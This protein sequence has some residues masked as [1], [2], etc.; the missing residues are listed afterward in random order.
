MK[1]I[2]ITSSNFP[3]GGA[4]A[5][6]LRLFSMGLAEKGWDVQVLL[7]K[8]YMYGRDTIKE[9]NESEWKN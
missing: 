8:G 6:Y 5:N 3:F 7:L 9:E 1:A 2:L 4:G